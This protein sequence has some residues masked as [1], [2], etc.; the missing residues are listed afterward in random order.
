MLTVKEQGDG[1]DSWFAFDYVLIMYFCLVPFGLLVWSTGLAAN[2]LIESVDAI[3]KDG[4]TGRCV[5]GISRDKYKFFTEPMMWIFS[6]LYTDEHLNVIRKSDGS[7]D[8]DV[9]AL[10]DAAVVKDQARLPATAQGLSANRLPKY[11]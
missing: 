5:F 10:G 1:W 3:E 8:P 9:W 4:K 2:P 11:R 7:V 6:S